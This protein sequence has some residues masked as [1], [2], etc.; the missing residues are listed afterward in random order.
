M[1]GTNSVVAAEALEM[2]VCSLKQVDNYTALWVSVKFLLCLAA[3][4]GWRWNL[5]SP[6]QHSH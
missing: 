3:M 4:Y 5:N 1:L 6:Q 2:S